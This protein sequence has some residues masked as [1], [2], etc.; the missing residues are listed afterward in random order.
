[1]EKFIEESKPF[2]LT[3]V[4]HVEGSSIGKPGFKMI[5]DEEGRIIAGTLGGVCPD[6]VIID[7]ALQSIKEGKPKKIKIF[8]EDA[9][10]ALKSTLSSSE[11]EIH[12]ETNCG[13]MMEV[14]IEPYLPERRIIIIGQGGKDDVEDELVKL[15]KMLD[16]K[17]I[18]IDHLPFL[19]VEPDMLIKDLDF[20]ISKLDL[21]KEDVV[22]VL[23]KG[24]RDIPV[25]SSLLK[26]PVNFIGLLASSKRAK[27][28]IEKLREL[29]FNEKDLERI[30]TPVGIDIGAIKPSEIALSIMAEVI[31][32]KAG[33]HY[34]HKG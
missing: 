13:G 1:M 18:V 27:M 12:V 15:A 19:S 3:T 32:F 29:G 8:L 28:D 7:R 22:I 23:T 25:L 9:A 17:T 4:V 10:T 11:D 14:Y 16:F 2:A 34:P 21:K 33:K 26:T 6:S 31:A 24:E 5:I 30:H 20:D